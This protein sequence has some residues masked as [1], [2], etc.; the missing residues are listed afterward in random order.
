MQLPNPLKTPS[1]IQKFL[2]ITDPIKY[3][4]SA[5]QQYADIFTGKIIGFGDTVVFVSHP[6]AI[7]Q[8][9][10]NDRKQFSSPGKLNR[11]MHP[12]LGKSSITFLENDSHKRRR[13]LL[14][15]HFHGE[16]MRV[17]GQT[18]CNITE[19]IWSCLPREKTFKAH[20]LMQDVAL[21]VILQVIFGFYEGE[22]CQKLETLIPLLLQIFESPFTSSFFMLPFLQKDLGDWTPWGK[23][24]RLRQQ[25]DELIYEEIAERREQFNPERIDMLSSLMLAKNEKGELLTDE[26]LRDELITQ[27]F[28]GHE[29]TSTMMAWTLYWIHK[30][31]EVHQK[32]LQELDTLGGFTDIMSIVRLPFLTAVCNE[33]MRIYPVSMFT[34]PRI[35]QEPTELLGHKLEPGTVVQ[36]LIYLAHQREESYPEPKEFKAERFLEH[37]F[38]PYE[39]LPFGGGMRGCIGSAFAQFEIKLVMATILSLYQLALVDSQPEKPRR[40]GVTIAPGNGV[41]M[42]MTGQRRTQESLVVATVN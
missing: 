29:T 19:K 6:E 13:Q 38:S 9:L 26:E 2:W 7:Q 18:I 10:S 4:E 20:T 42:V 23:F 41:R 22:R 16:R 12:I 39:F 33:A 5:S 21:Q 27:I 35:V 32:I 30:K 28:A 17:C 15:P 40:R 36:A 8:L 31:P 24:L 11:I 1:L 25:V 14:M 34:I 37:Q 3:M